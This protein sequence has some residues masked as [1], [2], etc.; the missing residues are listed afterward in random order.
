M[1]I[2]INN[3]FFNHFSDLKVNFN[4]DTFG[5]T[6]SFKARF[7][8]D[9][10]EH[11]KIFRPLSYNEIQIFSNDNN[12]L[13]TGTIVNNSF[14]SSQNPELVSLSGYSKS[15]ILQDVSIPLSVYPLEKNNQSLSQISS[16]MIKP[17]NIGQIID[18]S[19]ANELS[20]NYEKVVANV[21][22][23]VAGFLSK[24]AAQRNVIIGHTTKGDL[25]YFKAFTNSKSVR[26]Y[27]T[28]NVLSS[29]IRIDGQGF[30]RSISVLR[31]PSDTNDGASTVDS[32][33]NTIVLSDRKVIKTL[34]SGEDTDTSKAA[35]NV[36]AA[37]LKSLQV[38]IELP[39]IDYDLKCGQIVNFQNRELFIYKSQRFVV[40]TITYN[41]DSGSDTMSIS[42]LLPEAFSG[43]NPKNIFEI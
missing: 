3:K 2:K 24:L 6:F 31:Q 22:D 19:A 10:L 29:S 36:L 39:R 7:N 17:F 40:N 26:A 38:S 18:P 11:Q 20:F 41:E 32:I 21:S 23:T 27:T 28:K 4:L 5:S 16:Q 13:L 33:T 25:Y 43:E 9:N 37:E 14:S 42:L 12:L 8:P 1:K 35:N 15:G 30:H 34:S